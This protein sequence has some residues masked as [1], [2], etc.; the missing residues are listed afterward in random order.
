MKEA[1]QRMDA[2][3]EGVAAV[4]REVEQVLQWLQ[5]STAATCSINDVRSRQRALETAFHA[6]MERASKGK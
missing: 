3:R 2:Q 6:H 4:E 5:D 1:L